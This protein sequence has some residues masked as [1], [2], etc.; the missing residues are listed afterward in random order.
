M[1]TRYV[2]IKGKEEQ[3]ILSWAREGLPVAL[4]AKRTGR[5]GGTI[6]NFLHRKGVA[7]ATREEPYAPEPTPLESQEPRGEAGLGPMALVLAFEQRVREF[8]ETIASKNSAILHLE[9][10]LASEKSLRVEAQER[11]TALANELNEYK[12][13]HKGWRDQLAT[14]GRAMLTP[15]GPRSGKDHTER[16]Q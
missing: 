3:Q 5:T 4:V 15:L 14:A 13:R 11:V 6:K 1:G 16:K 8:H 2:H 12:W 7:P 9:H 10:E